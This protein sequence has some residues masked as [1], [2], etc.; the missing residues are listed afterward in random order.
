MMNEA[1]HGCH[2]RY[3]TATR[4]PHP[5]TIATILRAFTLAPDQAVMVGDTTHDVLMAN[6]VGMS[7]IAVTYGVHDREQVR[8]AGPTWI[9]DSFAVV[10]ELVRGFGG[11]PRAPQQG[12]AARPG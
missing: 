12:S 8:A 2:R 6:A 10:L 5:E 1:L 11:G 4:K 7:S 9:V 3:A